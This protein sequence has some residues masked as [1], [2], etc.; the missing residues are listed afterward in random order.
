MLLLACWFPAIRFDKLMPEPLI[1]LFSEKAYLFALKNSDDIDKEAVRFGKAVTDFPNELD[2][3][4]TAGESV[5]SQAAR[6][7]NQPATR[8]GRCSIGAAS[9]DKSEQVALAVLRQVNTSLHA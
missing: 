4:T 2:R 9:V 5:S 3:A 6:I 1:R 8:V 7:A